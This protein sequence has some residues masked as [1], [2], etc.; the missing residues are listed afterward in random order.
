MLFY[1]ILFRAVPKCIEFTVAALLVKHSTRTM[2]EFCSRFDCLVC[3]P[4]GNAGRI[5][6]IMRSDCVCC[7]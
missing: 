4:A 5:K 7:S 3:G 6:A 1:A 2:S